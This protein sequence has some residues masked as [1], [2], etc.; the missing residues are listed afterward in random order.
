MKNKFA[1][2]F[3][4]AACLFSLKVAASNESLE[5]IKQ[6]DVASLVGEG[7]G[8]SRGVIC[9]NDTEHCF[10]SNSSG[11]LSWSDKII[12]ITI[13][14]NIKAGGVIKVYDDNFYYI[15]E[16][17]YKIQPVIKALA[18]DNQVVTGLPAGAILQILGSGFG[19]DGG[20]VNF[21]NEFSSRGG[22]II[23]WGASLISVEIPDVEDAEEVF[24]Y[25][26]DGLSVSHRFDVLQPI[27]D[28]EYSYYQNYLKIIAIPE[29]WE[30][31]KPK[32]DVVVAIIDD[33]I[34]QNHE[35]LQGK[36]WSNPGEIIGNGID[37][38]A[39]GYVD[40]FLGYNFVKETNEVTQLGSHGT[41]VAGIIGA[42]RDNQIGVAGIAEKVK[43]MPLIVCSA[44]QCKTKD[45]LEAIYYAVDNGARVINIS[46][47]N[48]LTTGFSS[49]Y[50]E[51]IEYADDHNVLVVVS[52]GN[53]DPNGEVGYDLSK[54]PQSPVCN[55]GKQKGVIIGVG[56]SKR[57]GTEKAEWSNYGDCVDVY[58]PGEE[59]ASTIAPKS[60]AEDFY[61]TAAEGTSFSA[62]MVTGLAA[63]ILSAY[64]EI[65][66]AALSHYIVSNA[67]NGVL[68]A[69][70]T[71]E[72]LLENYSEEDNYLE[73]EADSEPEPVNETEFTD[74]KY[75][76]YREAIEYLRNEEIVDG[77][78]DNSFK[79][80]NT[81]N[82]A[83]FI[84]IVMEAADFTLE[85]KDC[86]DDVAT[87]WFA[88]YVCAAKENGVISGYADNTFKPERE[89]NVVEAFKITLNAFKIWT[90]E[91]RAGEEWF[92][93]FTEYAEQNN[94][95]LS[96]FRN[97]KNITRG[98]MS[99]II[100]RI[101]S[102]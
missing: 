58:A 38:D 71:I 66:N 89:I 92:V 51:A 62:P 53:G 18:Q 67:R 55:D 98:E 36:L 91:A 13:P 100:F 5:G 17:P 41:M 40:D 45:I 93:P 88:K 50:D 99:E 52:A 65:S 42:I 7:F 80:F 95:Y 21:G 94:L 28:D 73:I 86:F 87:Q 14:Y 49:D 47:G 19:E 48:K 33:G 15:T 1:F 22:K 69:E 68:D 25:P 12:K 82:R 84:K 2:V 29:A 59:I 20:S 101:L 102:K 64:P 77:Y 83:E 78:A 35:D 24:V 9:F 56:A 8:A 27:T 32:E 10:D 90:R 60:A 79:P 57:D 11:I 61:T 46:L 70:E 72:D 23:E 16:F 43:M 63:L 3:L 96:S 31:I 44:N 76:K 26:N 97:A 75:S 85:G 4:L 34:Y 81:I 37:D 39:N 54:I 6:D 74:I 30:L